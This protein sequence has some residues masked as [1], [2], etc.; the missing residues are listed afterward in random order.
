IGGTI[1]YTQIKDLH[2]KTMDRYLGGFFCLAGIAYGLI[3]I[4]Q[5]QLFIKQNYIL[6]GQPAVYL[7]SAL[8]LFFL[9]AGIVLIRH[10]SNE[11]NAVDEDNS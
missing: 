11:N 4:I 10:K 8:V 9:A 6:Q 2:K 5:K 1:I 7:G 3:A